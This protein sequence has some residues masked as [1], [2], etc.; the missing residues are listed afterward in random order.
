[1]YNEASVSAVYQQ[2]KLSYN[3]A[4]WYHTIIVVHKIF[5]TVFGNYLKKHLLLG[6]K[7]YFYPH[8]VAIA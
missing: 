7:M 2:P 6:M 4:C 3:V 1:M 5:K 8:N